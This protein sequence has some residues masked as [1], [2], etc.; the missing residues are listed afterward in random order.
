MSKSAIPQAFNPYTKIEPKQQ[1]F[2]DDPAKYKLIGGAQGGGKSYACRIEAYR[3]SCA[4]KKCKGLVLR[5]SRGEAIKNFVD[6]LLEET[7]IKNEDGTSTQSLK[8]ISSQN[9]IMFPNGSRIDIGYCENEKD[10]ERYRGLEYDWICVEELTQWPFE[11]WR[12]ITASM[13]TT[14]K[15]IRPFFFG[16]TNPGNIGHGWV[17][18]LFINQDFEKNEKPEDY[19][20]TRAT[21][22]DNPTLMAAD[23]EYLANLQSLPD[24]ERRARLD[25][26]WDVFE[27]QYFTEWRRDIHV[28]RPFIPM[29]GIKRRIICLDYGY[30]PHPSAVYWLAQFNSG[31]VCCYREL[32]ATKLRY[33]QLAAQCAALTTSTEEISVVVGDPSVV[34]KESES[35]NTFEAEFNAV[36]FQVIGGNNK[37]IEGW[38]LVRKYLSPFTDPNTGRMISRLIVTENC[39]NLIRVL[40]EQVHDTRNVEDMNTKGEDHPLDSLRYG[41]ME[42]GDILGTD[43]SF[44]ELNAG[45]YTGVPQA[46]KETSDLDSYHSDSKDEYYRRK[47]GDS[48]NGDDML[49]MRF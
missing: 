23:P 8:W 34:G 22:Y 32:Y 12:K 18:R 30:H 45:L 43:T 29:E 14:K 48:D 21:I 5:R 47:Y 19:G 38:N 7:R 33:D 44:G 49:S 3:S 40:P 31:H 25:G 26:D 16:S 11:W 36:G 20:M 39:S 4:L 17:K 24:K 46:K 28:V 9:K 37:R 2:L 27:G 41:L 35:G 1:Q 6:P 15:G 13:R 42:L 10:V